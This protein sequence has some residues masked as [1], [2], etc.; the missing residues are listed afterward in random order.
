[1]IYFCEIPHQRTLVYIV[2]HNDVA[3]FRQGELTTNNRQER[4]TWRNAKRY[5]ARASLASLELPEDDLPQPG[6]TGWAKR[7]VVVDKAIV[8]TYGGTVNAR[9]ESRVIGYDHAHLN[10]FDKAVGFGFSKTQL[11]PHAG[12]TAV[13]IEGIIVPQDRE[14]A[15]CF[16]GPDAFTAQGWPDHPFDGTPEGFEQAWRESALRGEP[17]AWP[18]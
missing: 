11:F 18:C 10:L 13:A 5:L 17:P 16:S 2:T 12:T 3:T 6:S 7:I 9:D 14:G 1:M 4:L 15:N 8:T